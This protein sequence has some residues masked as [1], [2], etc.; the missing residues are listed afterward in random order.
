MWQAGNARK[1]TSPQGPSANASGE[2]DTSAP[3]PSG[4]VTLTEF[5]CGVEAQLPG[6]EAGLL[7]S[8]D[9]PSPLPCIPSTGPSFTSQIVYLRWSLCLLLEEPRLRQH[10]ALTQYL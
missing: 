4:Q 8:L 3:S 5:P 9:W 7:V 6:V 2:R 10:M 1:P